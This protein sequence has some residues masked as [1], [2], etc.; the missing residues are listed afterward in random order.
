[1]VETGKR[2]RDLLRF[3]CFSLIFAV[4][5]VRAF[6]P[7][8]FPSTGLDPSWQLALTEAHLAGLRF[9]REIVFTFGPLGY[10][11][12]GAAV[13]S[14]YSKMFAFSIGL[15]AICALLAVDYIATGRNLATKF[16]F[17]LALMLTI[18]GTETV[19]LIL[20]VFMLMW[21]SVRVKSTA[22]SILP[23]LFIGLMSGAATL[24]KFN[25]GV[26][27]A[28][29][30]LCVFGLPLLARATERDKPKRGL[31]F[32]AFVVGLFVASSGPISTFDYG[33]PV[34]AILAT[35]AMTSVVLLERVTRRRLLLIVALGCTIALLCAPSYREF[36][37]HSLQIASG[38]S[39]AMVVEGARWQLP[40]ALCALAIVGLIL[41]GNVGEV[42]VPASFALAFAAFMEYKE[43][44][45][46]QD[47]HVIF[48]FWTAFAIAA[49]LVAR[50]G[51]PRL[52]RI[53]CISAVLLLAAWAVVAR[54]EG[55]AIAIATVYA[56]ATTFEDVKK[57]R[58]AWEPRDEL[59]GSLDAG[60]L[61][62]QLP[63]RVRR[64]IS[65][66]SAD[67]QPW[68]TGIVFAN[69]LAWDPS[70]VFQSYSAY[71]SGLDRLD[72]DHLIRSGAHY[73]VFQ[74]GGIDDRYALWDQPFNS[75]TLLCNYVV[76]DETSPVFTTQ[77]LTQTSLLKRGFSRCGSPQTWSEHMKWNQ[78][79]QLPRGSGLL[80]AAIDVR[81]SP[82]GQVVKLAYRLPITRVRVVDADG[83]V[84]AYRMLVDTI[85][86]GILIDPLPT[87][88]VE[89]DGL[90][91]SGKAPQIKSIE[92]VTDKAF[93]FESDIPVRFER[94]PYGLP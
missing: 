41:V 23:A 65:N 63:A 40:L 25:L 43:G 71:T 55:Q 80:F 46:R 10:L 62:D 2:R 22:F 59:Q 8:A 76:A 38:Y 54:D 79:M 44:F 66:N 85:Q 39:G 47:G 19:D 88:L 17:L 87:N 34:A 49:I 69:N 9:G 83:Q 5:F 48:P 33:W 11:A 20:L 28:V 73:I 64:E 81:L 32:V 93:L 37:A 61:P 12:A 70:P 86:D 1:M 58:H 16:A 94:V 72:A 15:A 24:F 84:A 92:L 57:L 52:L 7:P 27:A 45:V 82:I 13:P 42:G 21:A 14:A 77:N 3:A 26:A 31:T 78:Q 75:R 30:G 89:F 50:S 68:E 90:V 56:P 35:G 51:S 74:W 67:A 4:V 60:L 29:G 6:R 91:Q 18:T 53:N 36:V